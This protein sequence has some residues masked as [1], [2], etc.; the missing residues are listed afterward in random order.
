MLKILSSTWVFLP[1][2]LFFIA[3]NNFY[4]WNGMAKTSDELIADGIVWILFMLAFPVAVSLNN[5]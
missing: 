2:L 3:E 5:K 4:G 1:S